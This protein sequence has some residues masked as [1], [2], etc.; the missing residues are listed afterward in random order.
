MPLPLLAPAVISAVGGLASQGINYLGQRATN[1]LNLQMNRENNELQVYLANQKYAKDLE[2]WNRQNEYNSPLA[3]R[4]RMLQAGLNPALQQISTGTATSSPEMAMPQTTAGRADPLPQVDLGTS[5]LSAYDSY[6]QN[7][8]L[9]AETDGILIDNQTKNLRNLA[10]LNE[11]LSRTRGEHARAAGQEVLNGFISRNGELDLQLK[12]NQIEHIKSQTQLNTLE[13]V[14]RRDELKVLPQMLQLDIAK[15]VA[16]IVL[17]SENVNVARMQVFKLLAETDGL[18][19]SNDVARRTAD[20]LVMEAQYRAY[21]DWDARMRRYSYENAGE[22]DDWQKVAIG[23]SY[24]VVNT[25]GSI[26]SG[27]LGLKGL[28]KK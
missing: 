11:I 20:S 18:K 1:A 9:K 3:Q 22:H 10:T 27:A 5:L 2:Q 24:N 16:D 17:T 12:Q 13:S 14:R 23:S 21:P 6:S 19:I 25:V 8:R 15:R 26:V 4:N 7:Q 28:F